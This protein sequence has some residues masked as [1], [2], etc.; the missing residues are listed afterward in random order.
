[1]RGLVFGAFGEASQPVHQ[2]VD[3][4]ATSQ[5]TVAVPQWGRMGVEDSGGGEGHRGGADQEKALCGCSEGPV[6]HL[7][8]QA[9]ADR[10]RAA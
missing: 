2:L 6:P 7:A 3:S 8:R 9:V 10:D 1:M 4:L 5:V